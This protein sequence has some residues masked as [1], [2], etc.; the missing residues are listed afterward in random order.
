MAWG[1]AQ[2]RVPMSPWN[3]LL[4]CPRDTK[5]LCTTAGPGPSLEDRRASL[6]PRDPTSTHW[7]AEFQPSPY[8]GRTT[9][10]SLLAD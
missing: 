6:T 7:G 9:P 5:G 10:A 2:C 4:Q 1:L 8:R 3:G